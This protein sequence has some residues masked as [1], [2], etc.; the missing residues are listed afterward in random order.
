[1]KELSLP[2]CLPSSVSLNNPILE[3]KSALKPRFTLLTFLPRSCLGSLVSEV[4]P[5]SGDQALAPV[6][7]S[8]ETLSFGDPYLLSYS[9]NW[10]SEKGMAAGQCPT[11]TEYLHQAPGSVPESYWSS[12]SALLHFNKLNIYP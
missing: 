4:S 3:G 12:V 9:F 11:E 2:A 1:M 5:L 10:L 6:L 8:L 7:F